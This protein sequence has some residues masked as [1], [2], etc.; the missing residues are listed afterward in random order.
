MRCAL[1]RYHVRRRGSILSRVATRHRRAQG[2]SRPSRW[3]LLATAVPALGVCAA[4]SNQETVAIDCPR[5]DAE[6]VAAL[7][8]RLR[9]DLAVR[10]ARGRLAVRCADRVVL[11]SWQ[12][13]TGRGLS[14]E[15]SLGPDETVTE[16]RVLEATDHL[17][18]ALA[19]AEGAAA[20]APV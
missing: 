18:S 8:A 11:T 9:A 12:P 6:D 20:P 3:V 2:P 15:S 5:L 7:S 1:G 16:E 10:A 14:Q 4:A 19:P 17:F 13:E